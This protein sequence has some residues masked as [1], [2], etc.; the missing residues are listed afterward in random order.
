MLFKQKIGPRVVIPSISNTWNRFSLIVPASA[1]FS[2][3]SKPK[4]YLNIGG[5]FIFSI[6]SFYSTSR[7]KSKS[8][9]FFQKVYSDKSANN[10]FFIVNNFL[11]Q[12]PDPESA[13]A[14]LNY[15]LINTIL[16]YHIKDFKLSK[17][18]FD[19]L[20]KLTE[21]Q[22]LKFNELPLSK[23]GKVNLQN[24]LGVTKRGVNSKAGVYIFINKF[25]GESYVGSSGALA[26]RIN[27]DY[28]RKGKVYGKRPIELAIN[29]YGLSSFKLEVYVLSQELL[30]KVYPEFHTLLTSEAEGILPSDIL[31]MTSGATEY[32]K[33]IRNLVLAL[34]QIFI[35]LLNPK[36]NKL[37]VA[38][39][40]AGNKIQQEL[41]ESVFSKIRKMTYLYDVDKKE[42]IYQAD[43]RTLLSGA[44]G[45]KRRLVPKQLYLN[46]FLISDNL[47]DSKEYSN[48]LLSSKALTA[49]ISEIRDQIMEKSLRNFLPYKEVVREKLSKST[50]LINT[51]TKEEKVFPSL[52]AVALY[53]RELNPEYKASAGSLHNIMKRGGL[54]KGIFLV[55]YLVKNEDIK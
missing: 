29:K 22:P 18:A 36:Y 7:K 37:K 54:Y 35:I 8:P 31:N 39:S 13:K 44:M 3:V 11:K 21:G 40:A 19:L 25:T 2:L 42:L 9:D 6:G 34:E 30:N 20:M 5:K 23:E 49:F 52:N 51:V 55:R 38:G 32:R 17:E 50:E 28:L 24:M 41:M 10:S 27:D 46:R 1:A 26:S 14:N 43:S 45:I 33:G 48:N 12:Y 16:S 15:K 4:P 53:L 47:L